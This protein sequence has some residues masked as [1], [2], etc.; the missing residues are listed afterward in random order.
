MYTS[1]ISV[2]VPWKQP[3][4]PITENAPGRNYRENA[5]ETSG[6]SGPLVGSFRNAFSD[7]VSR[8]DRY[9]S[10]NISA[11]WVRGESLFNFL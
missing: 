5:P 6:C 11:G 2:Q 4:K 7:R 8:G 10:Q 9:S 3:E 1:E